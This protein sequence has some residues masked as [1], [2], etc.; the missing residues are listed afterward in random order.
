LDRE[1]EAFLD[2]VRQRKR[3][4][5]DGRTGLR[6]LELALKVQASIAGDGR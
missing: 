3:P 6:A 2:C 4:L 1:I 5:V